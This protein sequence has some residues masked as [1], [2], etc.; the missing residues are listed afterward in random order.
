QEN[1]CSD[2]VAEGSALLVEAGA[3]QLGRTPDEQAAK[4]KTGLIDEWATGASKAGRRTR[5]KMEA[6][7]LRQYFNPKKTTH[8][9][10][11]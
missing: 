7:F 11:V 9:L 8:E 10:P 2:D 3:A 6:E 4:E 5:A 1:H